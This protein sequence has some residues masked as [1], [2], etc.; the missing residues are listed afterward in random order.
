MS[1][2]SFKKINI[3]NMKQ[4]VKNIDINNIKRKSKEIKSHQWCL[5]IAGIIMVLLGIYSMFRSEKA[6]LSI[7]IFVGAGLIIC[8][9]AHIFAYRL[10]ANDSV[11]HPNWF[12][13][14]GLFEIILGF[15]L[16]ANLGVTS[17]S[18]PLMVAFWAIFD[19]VMRTT[20][21]F[22][23]KCAGVAKWRVLLI[24]GIISLF[25]ALILLA[26]PFATVIGATFMI[27]AA[28]F[29]WG[30]TAVCEARHLYD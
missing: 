10:H 1:K 5:I 12:M 28:L 14:Q 29:A 16:I 3:E 24:T 8:G 25:F 23:L 11:G 21:S 2:L 15:I 26:R 13:P 19:G 6:I 4:K 9:I 27:G 22:Q 17:L 7:V 18:A 20:A 30:I